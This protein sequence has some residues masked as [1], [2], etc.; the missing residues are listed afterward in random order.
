MYELQNIYDLRLYADQGK[1][2][3]TSI[4]AFN[5]AFEACAK[6]EVMT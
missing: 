5:E 6:L 1:M 4:L 2:M 3:Q